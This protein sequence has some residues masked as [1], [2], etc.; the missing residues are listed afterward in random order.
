MEDG[1]LPEDNVSDS[2]NS[3]WGSSSTA[4]SIG[5]SLEV[6]APVST[7]FVVPVTPEVISVDVAV[8][9]DN[10]HMSITV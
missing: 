2:L 3:A 6:A 10:M 5:P 7:L 9:A 8:S 1:I 4:S